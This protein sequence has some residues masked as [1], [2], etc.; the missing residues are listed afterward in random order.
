M[1]EAL[2]AGHE[3]AQIRQVVT[4]GCDALNADAEGK[5]AVLLGINPHVPED[6][7]VDHPAAQDFEPACSLAEAAALAA[8]DTAAN[9]DF[10][11][12]LSEWE[13]VRAVARR[14]ISTKYLP[15]KIV[16]CALQVAKRDPLIY[17]KTFYLRKLRQV[18]CVCR[19][20]AK[21]GSGADHVNGRLMLLHRMDL[22]A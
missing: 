9:I 13:E 11:A 7:R 15:R 21:N 20:R 4:Q 6:V 3:H 16:E 14:P 5:A 19:I 12:R 10:T 22:D 8:A 18:V 2:I 17:D 1:E